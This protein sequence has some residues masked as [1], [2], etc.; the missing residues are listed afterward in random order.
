MYFRFIVMATY[1]NLHHMTTIYF[2]AKWKMTSSKQKW[3]EMKKVWEGQIWNGYSHNWNRSEAGSGVMKSLI[4]GNLKSMSETSSSLHGGRSLKAWCGGMFQLWQMG[5]PHLRVDICLPV[6]SPGKRFYC[7]FGARLY[8][9]DEWGEVEK[10]DLFWLR[11][12]C[13]SVYCL[14]LL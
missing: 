8:W 2:F 14:W 4:A 12:L 7:V 1:I 5:L 11:W 10:V 9:E 13:G 6:I 3:R